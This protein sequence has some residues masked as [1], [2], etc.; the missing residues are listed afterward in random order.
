LVKH[1]VVSLCFCKAGKSGGE[2]HG[3]EGESNGG[4]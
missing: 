3:S 2:G 4:A 1:L